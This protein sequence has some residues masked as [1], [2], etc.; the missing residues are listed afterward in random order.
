MRSAA[1]L[2]GRLQQGSSLKKQIALGGQKLAKNRDYTDYN[3][4]EFSL[5]TLSRG[6]QEKS[7]TVSRLTTPL[8]LEISDVLQHNSLENISQDYSYVNLKE[9]SSID[10]QRTTKQLSRRKKSNNSMQE[11][12]LGFGKR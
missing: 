7:P 5:K 11:A 10:Y 6:A 9:D 2:A 8:Q 4:P 3:G 12:K 1:R